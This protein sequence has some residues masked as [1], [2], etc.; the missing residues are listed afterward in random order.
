MTTVGQALD[1]C[2]DCT[3]ELVINS[4]T[5]HTPAWCCTNLIDLWM[6]PPT[7]GENVIIDEL[8]GTRPYWRQVDE[9]HHS[10]PMV[11]TG[12]C[13]NSGNPAT[14]FHAQLETNLDYLITNVIL[15]PTEPTAT[16]PAT[17]T[18]PSGTTRT[19]DVQVTG[20]VTVDFAN[21]FLLGTL[22]LTIPEGYFT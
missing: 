10:L 4:V 9:S 18:L 7:R 5:L 8:P 12:V 19:A 3:G 15:P 13:D 1:C 11:I 20:F 16:Y 6:P 2:T 21:Y 22:E 14:D 17:L